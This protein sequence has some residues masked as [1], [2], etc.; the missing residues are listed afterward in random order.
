MMRTLGLSFS[1]DVNS[2]L[3]LRVSMPPDA[4]RRTASH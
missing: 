2:S 1:A 3:D 4:K